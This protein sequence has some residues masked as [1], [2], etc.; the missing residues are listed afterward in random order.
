LRLQEAPHASYDLI[1]LDA[2]SSDA[3]PV[4]LVT[5]EAIRI[6]RER[7]SEHGMLAFHI[8]NRYIDLAPVLGRLATDAGLASRERADMAVSAEEAKNGKSAS[9]WI[10]MAAS[11]ADLGSLA[12]DPRWRVPVYS[13]SQRVWTDDY[14]DIVRHISWSPR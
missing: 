11:E 9:R 8:S 5:R 14:S 4:H 3:V 2:F 10:V 7:M 13:K 12:N 1:V 6:Y